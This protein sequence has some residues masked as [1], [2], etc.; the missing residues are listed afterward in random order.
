[1]NVYRHNQ[2]H[3][4]HTRTPPQPCSLLAASLLSCPSITAPTGTV[5]IL[6]ALRP[7]LFLSFTL[8]GTTLKIPISLYISAWHGIHHVDIPL[9]YASLFNPLALF[10]P[11]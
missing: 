5:N 11:R 6:Y 4:H 2:T 1:M 10:H 9:Q 3:M 8:N 7:V